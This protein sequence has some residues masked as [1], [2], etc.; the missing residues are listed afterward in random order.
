MH[1]TYIHHHPT[2]T[3]VPDAMQCPSSRGYWGLH[4]QRR[5][6]VSSGSDQAVDL[7]RPSRQQGS[8]QGLVYATNLGPE[9][10]P[11]HPAYPGI[12]EVVVRSPCIPVT[13]GGLG[14]VHKRPGV[15]GLKPGRIACWA[16]VDGPP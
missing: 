11:K 13:R 9:A 15:S 5:V 10:A 8:G 12:D 6:A 14:E 7:L 3:G 1:I 4:P 2:I 16:A